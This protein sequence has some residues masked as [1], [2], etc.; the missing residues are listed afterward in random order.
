MSTPCDDVRARTVAYLLSILVNGHF[1]S[2]LKRGI[3][4]RSKFGDAPQARYIIDH[5]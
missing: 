1:D 4:F 2:L 5:R 3:G